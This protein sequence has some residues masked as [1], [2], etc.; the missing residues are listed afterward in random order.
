MTAGVVAAMAGVVVAPMLGLVTGN[1]PLLAQSRPV[2]EEDFESGL[3]AWSFPLGR[4]HRIVSEGAHRIVSEAAAGNHALRL[5]TVDGPV[6]ALVDGSAEWGDVR[7]EGRVLFPDDDHNYLGF[8][9]RYRATG[10]RIDF[11]SVYIKG[12]GSYAQANEHHDTNVGRTVYPELR[13]DLEDERAI[14]IGAW[15][16]FA[17]EV[18]GPEAHLYVGDVTTPAMTLP[19][20]AQGSGSFGFKPRN[21]G[22]GVWI[23][24]IRVTTIDGFS[25]RGPPIPDVPYGRDAF[26]TDWHVLGPLPEHALEV[27][28]AD[29]FDPEM[30]ARSGGQTLGWRPYSTDHR[31]AVLTGRITEFRGARRVAYFHATVEAERE[32]DAELQLSTVDDL[33]IWIDGTF[34]GYASGQPYAW[35]D[36]GDEPDHR[37]LRSRITL[38]RG[39]N[40][41]LIRALGGTYATGGFYLRIVE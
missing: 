7:I 35:W 23:D 32:G 1:E 13:T 10:R 5:Q 3:D 4:G 27:E 19:A 29:D 2:F 6:Y 31:G 38:R 34:I 37:P 21:P 20:A 30:S 26:V 8:I 16:R 33:A 28:T 18:V 15:Q 17:L 25:Y 12:N 14:E 40:D 36:V 22:A 39:S 9:Y 11:G 41:V 24:D